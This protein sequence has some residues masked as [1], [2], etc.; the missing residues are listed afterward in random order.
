MSELKAGLTVVTC[1][2]VI[3]FLCFALAGYIS[4]RQRYATFLESQRTVLECRASVA[5]GRDVEDIC[6]AIPILKDFK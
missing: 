1:M 6:G 2:I 5:S 4:T 3:P